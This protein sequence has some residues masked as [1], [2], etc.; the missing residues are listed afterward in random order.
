MY[1]IQVHPADISKHVR[2]YFLTRPT[3]RWLMSAVGLVC[4]V[5]LVGLLLAPLGV[6]SLMISSELHVLTRQHHLYREVLDERS[7]VLDRLQSRLDEARLQQRQTALVLGASQEEEGLGGFPDPLTAE[8]TVPDA[9]LAARRAARAR[10]EAKALL[11]LADE[12][13]R[14]ARDN[15]ELTRAVPSI[16]PVPVGSFVLTSPFGERI[17]PFTNARDFHSGIDLAA[18]E[19]VPVLAS[20][21][22]RVVFAGRFPLRR[23]VRWWRYGNVVVI[24]HQNGQWV[25]V[26]AHLQEMKVARGALVTRGDQIGTVGNTGWSTSPHLHYE[27]RVREPED[28]EPTPVDPRIFILNYRWTGHERLLAASRAAP[29][30]EYDPLP[31]RL[32]GR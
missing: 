32:P 18:R 22:G 23:N 26:Y 16:C 8:L 4:L 31:V 21:D 28:D 19:G 30:P 13:E 14:F 5:I 12:L 17:S 27:V 2:Y 24:S 6:R 10:T 1:E 20:G 11:A 9:V 25:T 29:A 3:V 7:R 15:L